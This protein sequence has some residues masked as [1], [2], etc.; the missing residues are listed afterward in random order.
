MGFGKNMRTLRK[1]LG[2]SQEKLCEKVGISRPALSRYE[3]EK[4]SPPADVAFVIAAV[5]GVTI[6]CLMQK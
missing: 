3:N 2:I 6:D 5:L 4:V 1:E